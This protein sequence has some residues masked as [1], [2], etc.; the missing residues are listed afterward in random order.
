MHM[1]RGGALSALL[2]SSLLT[3]WPTSA[4]AQTC[5]AKPAVSWNTYLG[6]EGQDVVEDVLVNAAGE[7]LVA[8]RT[9]SRSFLKSDSAGVDLVNEN[10][11]VAK[12]SA[13]GKQVLWSRV[14][15]TGGADS[16]A[17]MA[18]D[19]NGDV[20]VVGRVEGTSVRDDSGASLFTPGTG[21]I[22]SN[23][24]VAK[25][26]AEGVLRSV[27]FLGGD[28][29]DEALGVA[30][31]KNRLYVVG[32][33]N[34]ALFS[35]SKGPITTSRGVRGDGHD[36]FVVQVDV[37]VELTPSPVWVRFLGTKK[38]SGGATTADDAAH[39]VV[40]STEDSKVVLFVGGVVRGNIAETDSGLIPVTPGFHGTKDGFVMQLDSEG[41][42][43][44]LVHL[45]GNGSTELRD[46]LRQPNGDLVAVGH[47][48]A[49]GFPEDSTGDA[50]DIFA[51]AVTRDG[52]LSPNQKIRL[53]APGEQFTHGRAAIDA[54]GQL[55]I[56]GSTDGESFDPAFMMRGFSA[57]PSPLGDGFVLALDTMLEQVRWGSYVGGTSTLA[58]LESVRA[59]ALDGTGGRLLIAGASKA[60]DLLRRDVGYAVEAPGGMNGFLIGVGQDSTAP[61]A[62]EVRASLN[63]DGR[64]T[65]T[66]SGF[67]DDESGIA[68]YE[69][70]ITDSAQVTVRDFTPVSDGHATAE[71][72]VLKR[73]ERY[74]VHVRAT[75]G[76]GCDVTVTAQE[77]VVLKPPPGTPGEET[78][79]EPSPGPEVP[80]LGDPR[81]PL[82]WGC[83]VTHPGALPGALGLV[84]LGL[85]GARRARRGAAPRA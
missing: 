33:T 36:A 83:G 65:A 70:S 14:F 1:G 38:A 45:G 20:Y 7:I 66:W 62:G 6:G 13:D 61:S 67:K 74:F 3:V 53:V 71:S 21:M 5:E 75:N 72:L 59:L 23:A 68:K 76:V 82:G 22:G 85:F 28:G 78:P 2:L 29:F 35:T 80:G 50:T 77:S 73:G 69:W 55:L 44:W 27:L 64:I 52:S 79:G 32:R 57:A 34:S 26:T 40:V 54:S 81:S 10:A 39:A 51:H 56:G 43:K 37:S 60:K 11:F 41:A 31:E 49:T 17:R 46:L 18:L 8:G 24:F 25:L 48:N 15:G 58:D 16:A 84:L 63:P 47:T 12:L 9:N 19:E 30:V 42:F 4:R